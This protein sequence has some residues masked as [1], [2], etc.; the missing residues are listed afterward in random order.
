MPDHPVLAACR[1][2]AS[3][4][5]AP[6]DAAARLAVVGDLPNSALDLF[7]LARDGDV[8]SAAARAW[9]YAGLVSE[10]GLPPWIDSP[11]WTSPEVVAALQRAGEVIDSSVAAGWDRTPG[12][13][14]PVAVV[15][16]GRVK[17]GT[18]EVADLR[19]H[20]LHG[21]LS[22]LTRDPAAQTAGAVVVVLARGFSPFS[23]LAHPIKLAEVTSFEGRV[24]GALPLKIS[25]IL[26]VDEPFVFSSI[27]LPILRGVFKPKI[28]SRIR[29]CG[30]SV[31]PV[32]EEL[33]E[34]AAAK[35]DELRGVL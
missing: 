33:G 2:L 18:A 15:R 31:K 26:A 20:M 28:I 19:L 24:V 30:A 4:P 12:D 14:R 34:A 8:P 13:S 9:R 11:R 25:R 7:L 16:P 23:F 35:V 1:A 29:T 32:A 22:V 21:F 17:L 6:S 5:D 27:V 10:F 3:A